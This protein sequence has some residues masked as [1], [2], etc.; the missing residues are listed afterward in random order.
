MYTAFEHRISNSK[1]RFVFP[2]RFIIMTSGDCMSLMIPLRF[3]GALWLPSAISLKHAR[4]FF[5][6]KDCQA[7]CFK[8]ACS[9]NCM[10]YHYSSCGD[11]HMLSEHIELYFK[12]ELGF[13]FQKQIF[14]DKHSFNWYTVFFDIPIYHDLF[15]TMI[16]QSLY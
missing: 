6:Y 15:I 5:N 4:L 7:C 12:R 2:F 9:R 1:Q 3:Q 11:V 16:L 13:T 8:K 14:L 10:W